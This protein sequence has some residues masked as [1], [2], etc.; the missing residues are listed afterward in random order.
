MEADAAHVATIYKSIRGL[1]QDL[2]RSIAEWNRL[3]SECDD[4]AAKLPSLASRAKMVGDPDTSLGVL[5]PFPHVRERIIQKQLEQVTL[6]YS[7][8]K[9]RMYVL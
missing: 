1:V 7:A 5:A 9:A 4:L 2:D 8:L 6:V 3:I